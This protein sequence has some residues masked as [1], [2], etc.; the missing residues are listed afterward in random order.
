MEV[1]IGPLEKNTG[2]ISS[3]SF[4]YP[5]FTEWFNYIKGLFNNYHTASELKSDRLEAVHS[6]GTEV[7]TLTLCDRG[8]QLSTTPCLLIKSCKGDNT[9]IESVPVPSREVGETKEDRTKRWIDLIQEKVND[10]LS[11]QV[12]RI[13]WVD[14][15]F[16]SSGDTSG[17]P[18]LFPPY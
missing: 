4:S 12:I 2:Y 6:L 15:G 9:I 8:Y 17:V 7:F 13:Q 18:P 11:Q 5:V 16:E 3:K 14:Y 1:F 10:V